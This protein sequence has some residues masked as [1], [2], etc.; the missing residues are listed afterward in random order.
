QNAIDA[1]LSDAKVFEE[2]KE[3][4]RLNDSAKTQATL[5]SIPC[6]PASCTLRPS[7]RLFNGRVFS[8]LRGVEVCQENPI[9]A[10]VAAVPTTGA[11]DDPNLARC[12]DVLYLLYLEKQVDAELLKKI[13]AKSNAVEKAFNVYR[14]KVDGKEMTDSEVRKVLKESKDSARRKA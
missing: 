8:R 13:V 5:S 6:A 9:V 4:K 11:I 14:A 2:L 7:R 12:I 1:A 10:S 3:L